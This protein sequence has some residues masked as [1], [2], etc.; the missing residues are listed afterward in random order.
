MN[1]TQPVTSSPV[2]NRLSRDQRLQ[3]KMLHESGMNQTR[4]ADQLG[5][6]RRQVR[7]TLSV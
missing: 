5:V 7:Y 6:T 1:Q 3:I 4:I 2:P